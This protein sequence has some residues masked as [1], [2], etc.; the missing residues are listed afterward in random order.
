MKLQEYKNIASL[1]ICTLCLGACILH[2]YQKSETMFRILPKIMAVYFI[3]DLPVTRQ[4]DF[5]IHHTTSIGIL[6]YTYYYGVNHTEFEQIWYHLL[7]TEISTIF[8][9]FRYYFP[10]NTILYNTNL[11]LFYV[12][13]TKFRMIDLYF[14]FVGPSSSIY[15]VIQKYTPHSPLVNALFLSCCYTLYGLNIYWYSI[16]NRKLIDKLVTTK[17]K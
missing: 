15:V 9:I 13:F 17:N 5:Q 1:C 3:V 8:L 2:L 10:K 6:F 11:S 14:H 12:T 4:C 7:K 16:M